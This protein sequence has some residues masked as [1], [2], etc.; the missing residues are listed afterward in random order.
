[1][2]YFHFSRAF[3]QSM[4]MT[5]TN[6]IAERRIE[7]AKKMLEE[8]EL[9]IPRSRCARDFRARVTLRPRF[10]ASPVQRQKLSGRLYKF[11]LLSP[12]TTKKHKR[13]KLDL[14]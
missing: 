13:H 14:C 2:S 6:Y 12:K 11:P 10:A 8:T 3:K 4:G 7:R 9:P 1:M 5:P